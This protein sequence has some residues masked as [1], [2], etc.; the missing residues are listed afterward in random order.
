MEETHKYHLIQFPNHFSADQKLK[1][2]IQAL[3]IDLFLC[4]TTLSVKKCFITST[5][6]LL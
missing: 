4:F 3:C 6:N 2:N 1:C 5:L